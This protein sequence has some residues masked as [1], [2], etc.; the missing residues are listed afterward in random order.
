MA[1]AHSNSVLSS[2]LY[3][4]VIVQ[5][6]VLSVCCDLWHH[7]PQID[8]CWEHHINNRNIQIFKYHNNSVGYIPWEHIFSH[9]LTIYLGPYCGWLQCSPR[10][11]S[12]NWRQECFEVNA[13]HSLNQSMQDKHVEIASLSNDSWSC[14]WLAFQNTVNSCI[15]KC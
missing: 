10:R 5:S 8:W 15:P 1:P 14:T 7:L 9:T 3:D 4:D 2:S 13:A 12:G 11:N 6:T